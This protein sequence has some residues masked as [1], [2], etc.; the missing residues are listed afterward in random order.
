MAEPDLS[1]SVL[2]RIAASTRLRVGNA[3]AA[4]SEEALRER[5]AGA[6][7][8]RD[9]E[10]AFK[11]PGLR[12]ISEFKRSSPSEGPLAEG[13]DAGRVA[14]A[15]QDAGAAALS[16]MT[17][18]EFFNGSLADLESARAASSL[19]VLMKDFLLDPYQ[20][21]Q[22]RAAGADIAL[23]IVALLGP[24]RTAAMLE[25]ARALGLHALVEVHTED[26][27]EAAFDAG[28]R[29]VGVNNRNLKTLEVDLS[30]GRTLA[31]KARGRAAVLVCESGLKRRADLETMQ[32]AG[33]DAFLIGSHLMKS[34]RPGEA[35]RELL[36]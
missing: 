15:Y 11:G 23:L 6:V 16:V 28:A 25:E 33:F 4:V 2:G 13:F 1:G 36:A 12:V 3:K 5:A 21:L 10:A 19:P 20:L 17:E 29:I 34:G 22:A 35:L 27:L 18:P 14:R 32:T 31:G 8:V 26:E 9:A 30:A 7:P 24:K